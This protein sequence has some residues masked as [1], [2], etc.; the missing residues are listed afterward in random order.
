MRPVEKANVGEML[1]LS[2]GTVHTVTQQYHPYQD[3]KSAL[4]A[5]LGGFC[6]YCE[7]AYHKERDLAV[8]H[9]QPKGLGQYAGLQCEWSNFLLGC[10]TCNGAD[11]KDTKDVVLE[12]IHLP[13]RN[14]T[15]KSLQ[16]RSGGVVVVNTALT[17]LSA[18]HA[19]ALLEL[20]G[21]D[22]SP[23]T[24][25]RGDTRWKKRQEDWNIASVYRRRYQTGQIDED[26]VVELAKSQ[27]GWSIWFT[28]FKG[29]DEVRRRLITDFPGT[30]I[31]CFDPNNHYEP[32][33]RNPGKADPV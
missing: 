31:R 15:Y 11:N 33:D 30:C 32:I 9:V 26:V 2:N 12:E 21:L 6:S 13:H 7:D 24:S 27:G 1:T 16:Y 19:K 5:N 14:N 8:E 29:C 4:V 17:G 25:S 10:S 3:A 18:I 28:V 20:V 22:K 23:M